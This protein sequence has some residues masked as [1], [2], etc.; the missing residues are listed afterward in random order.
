MSAG[1][2]ITIMPGGGVS[3]TEMGSIIYDIEKR[4]TEIENRVNLEWG[5]A[6]QEEIDETHEALKANCD[7]QSENAELR[8]ELDKYKR[9]VEK[10]DALEKETSFDD[11]MFIDSQE[12][13]Q[14]KKECL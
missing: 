5:K 12:W 14:L 7:L 2:M 13:R 1:Y 8:K 10:I 6:I 9:L 3:A 11:D 4:L